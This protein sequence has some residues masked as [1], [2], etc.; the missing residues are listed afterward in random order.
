[1]IGKL[2]INSYEP[3]PKNP[4]LAKFFKEVGLADL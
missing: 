2:D 1:M 3:Y 4:K